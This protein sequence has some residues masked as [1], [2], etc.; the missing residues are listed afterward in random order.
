MS[1]S[2]V[3]LRQLRSHY[4]T[5][6]KLGGPIL[7]GQLGMIVVGFAD[8]AMVGHY[9]TDALASASFVNN[10]FNIAILM[11]MGFSLGLTPLIGSLFTR[12]EDDDIGVTLREGLKLNL[13]YSLLLTAVMTV[14]YFNLH[15]LGQPEHLLPLIRPYFLIY[16]AG[17]LP[18]A[19]FQVF[20]QCAYAVNSTKM[21]MWIILSANVVN[22]IGNY[23]LIYGNLGA[24]ELGLTGAGIATFI[25]RV[26]CP[27]AIYVIF[28][29]AKRFKGYLH[30]FFNLK[31][32]RKLRKKI[33]VTSLPVSLQLG[34]ETGSFSLAAIMAGWLGGL[35]LASFQILFTIGMLGFCVY[36]SFGSAISVVVAN[37][38][39]EGSHLKMRQMAMA[40]Y[41]IILAFAF[42]ACLVF[43]FL[44]STLISIFT[45]D[46]AVVAM[47]VGCIFPLILYQLSDATQITFANALRGTSNVMPML[48]TS[49]VSYIVIGVPATYLFAFT[50]NGD[51]F[52]IVLSFTVSLCAAAF[53]YFYF[54]MKTTRGDHKKE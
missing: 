39:G 21:P 27:V 51:L 15:N 16:L 18:I 37:A 14:V 44:G 34:F 50:F 45:T 1:L 38:A 5:I 33:F 53:L 25:A 41:H 28:R 13:V 4:V 31:G 42:L 6:L 43:Y 30:G 10:I 32:S 36:Y 23:I 12:N 7:V 26:L 22:I 9:S 40:G 2:G 19:F 8:S 54:F 29:R 49:F 11:C 3:R 52:G 24:P 48:L 47:T 35:Q 17:I 20:A 46:P